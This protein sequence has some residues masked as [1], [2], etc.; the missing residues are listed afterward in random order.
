M[1]LTSPDGLEVNLQKFNGEIILAEGVMFS[2]GALQY[3]VELEK[4][5]DLA[6]HTSTCE[7]NGE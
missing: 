2:K 1:A 4:Y 5:P 6:Y 3:R 7:E